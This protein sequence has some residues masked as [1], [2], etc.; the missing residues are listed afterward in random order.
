MASTL[1]A[2]IN[3]IALGLAALIFIALGGLWALDRTHHWDAPRWPVAGAAALLPAATNPE[4]RGAVIVAVNL[5]C[6]H[7]RTRLL[8]VARARLAERAHSAL[9][10]LIVDAPGRPGRV[11]FGV[12]LPA[13]AWWDSLGTWRGRWGR[14]MYGEVYLFA[15]GGALVRVIERQDSLE[16]SPSR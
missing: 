1:A 9:G 16:A 11:E 10:V 12:P 13:G 3:R 2:N 7:C 8:E 6:S 14:R 5:D 15:P 4:G